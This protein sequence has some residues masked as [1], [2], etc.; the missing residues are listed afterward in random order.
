MNH[1]KAFWAE[2]NRFTAEL[3]GLWDKN[4][5][6]EGFW[7]SGRSLE[8]LSS[9]A[10]NMVHVGEG[11]DVESLCGGT[12]RSKGRKRRRG[13]PG[14]KGALTWK[15]QRNRRFEKK[16]GKNGVALG[17]D[18]DARIKL[19][20]SRRG[21][22]GGKPRVAGSKRG[23]ELRAAAALARLDVEIEPDKV[24]GEEQ[25]EHSLETD[26]GEYGA[27]EAD[28]PNGKAATDI[29]G[30]RL[31][32][33]MGFGMTRVCGDEDIGD[34]VDVKKEMEDF[35]TLESHQ[36]PIQQKPQHSI[37]WSETSP[38][39][40]ESPGHIPQMKTPHSSDM[41][42]SDHNKRALY[43][44]PQYRAPP[45]STSPLPK[46]PYP[47]R[48]SPSPAKP[49]PRNPIANQTPTH[50]TIACS[51]P[52][53]TS[54]TSPTKVLCPLCSTLNNPHSDPTCTACSHVLDRRKDP[55]AWSCTNRMCRGSEYVNAGDCGVCGGC[56]E[57][58]GNG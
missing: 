8:N 52:S 4:Y 38:G 25:A 12:F 46:T 50:S 10:G 30:N 47:H 5:T 26:D 45:S 51:P 48:K 58:R 29:N 2:R 33:S 34:D 20:I 1:G 56:G 39:A 31:L 55:R 37:R 17:E 44:I 54:T 43:S 16:F 19:E 42:H 49:P 36:S 9:H 21:P 28:A 35:E 13:N 14:G 32:D 22:L 57:R 18:E 11:R 40:T 27:V 24:K 41:H 6:G 15:E 53:S 3:K 7:G 23:R